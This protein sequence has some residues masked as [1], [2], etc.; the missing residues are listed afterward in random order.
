MDQ[1]VYVKRLEELDPSSNF[2]DFRSVRMRL[3]WLANTCPDLLI[4]IYQLAQITLERFNEGSAAHWKR[5]NSAI[6]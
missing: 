2:S 6:R 3:A 5:L 1:T 4:E